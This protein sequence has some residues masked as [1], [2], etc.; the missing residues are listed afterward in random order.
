MTFGY[1]VLV[2][3]LTKLG[4]CIENLDVYFGH[5]SSY[6]T[7]GRCFCNKPIFRTFYAISRKT[8]NVYGM[9]CDCIMRCQP[10]IECKLCKKDFLYSDAGQLS[11]RICTDCFKHTNGE[12]EVTRGK[13]KGFSFEHVY[14]LDSRYCNY[15]LEM[16][17]DL[18][19][20]KKFNNYV[21]YRNYVKNEN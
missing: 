12:R 8:G 2:A 17:G 7:D 3:R 11:R 6:N 20:W 5:Q 4:D 21:I 10:E 1:H 9:G 18:P 16:K 19:G 15:M 14:N 13:Y